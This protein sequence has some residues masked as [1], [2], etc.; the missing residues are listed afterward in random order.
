MQFCGSVQTFLT[1]Q[2]RGNEE[3]S[4]EHAISFDGHSGGGGVADFGMHHH[5]HRQ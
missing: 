5:P 3:S 4:D 2:H 1:A